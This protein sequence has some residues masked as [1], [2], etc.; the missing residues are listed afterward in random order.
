MV[1]FISDSRLFSK[2]LL[3]TLE[4]HKLFVLIESR[5]ALKASSIPR[6]R[7]SFLDPSSA[8]R[9]SVKS[10]RPPRGVCCGLCPR[11]VRKPRGVLS[12]VVERSVLAGRE[13]LGGM[14]SAGASNTRI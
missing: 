4:K 5:V 12:A 14:H 8:R 2:N 3:N 7:F 13:D 9:L 1:I 6:V 10:E 11:G